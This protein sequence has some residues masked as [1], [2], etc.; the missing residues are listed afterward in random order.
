[1]RTNL[2]EADGLERIVKAALAELPLSGAIL[3]GPGAATRRLADT[4]P[5]D[6]PLTVVTNA[7][8]IAQTLAS[9]PDVT[10]VLLGGRLDPRTGAAVDPWAME[11]LEQVYAEVTFVVPDG[12][13][14]STPCMPIWLPL[15][16]RD[17]WPAPKTWSYPV[18]PMS[19]AE[20]MSS[21]LRS[22]GV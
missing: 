21:C 15:D 10:V 6:L 14:I 7:V 17:N 2:D 11:K 18:S 16:A 5:A 20:L 22:V 13:V 4:L 19:I 1:M 8:S 9:R 3:L 12:S